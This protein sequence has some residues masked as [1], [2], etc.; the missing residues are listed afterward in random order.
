MVFISLLGYSEYRADLLNGQSAD[1]TSA[2]LVV[3]VAEAL[4]A[5]EEALIPSP[6]GLGV[7]RL[8]APV[9]V[10]L[11]L[12]AV[13]GPQ[14]GLLDTVRQVT[15]DALGPFN[16]C[17]VRGVVVVAGEQDDV[18]QIAQGIADG[19]DVDFSIG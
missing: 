16:L 4:A 9:Q 1:G 2:E 3:A 13:V 6:A 12:V 5:V 8:V 18:V 17:L 11:E 10:L 7:V 15:A 14:H 19:A